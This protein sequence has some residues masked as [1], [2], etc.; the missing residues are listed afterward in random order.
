[1]GGQKREQKKKSHHGC[2]RCKQR[3]CDEKRPDCSNCIKRQEICHYAAS[4]P[5]LWTQP[6]IHV[7]HANRTASASTRGPALHRQPPN[8]MSRPAKGTH[9][10]P[11]LMT[12]IPPSFP[13]IKTSPH[14]HPLLL[15]WT[16]S[17]CHSIARTPIDGRIWQTVIPQQALRC[18]QLFHGLLAVS[19][20]HLAL[21]QSTLAPS[22]DHQKSS[23]ITAAEHH[24]SAAITLLTQAL[25]ISTDTDKTTTF[26]LSCLLVGFAF[27]F[28]LAVTQD[29]RQNALDDLL[30]IF[31][32]IH[33]MM[34]FSTPTIPHLRTS[35]MGDL[36]HL[37]HDDNTNTLKNHLPPNLSPSSRQ[38]ITIILQHLNHSL[39]RSSTSSSREYSSGEH[40][41]YLTTITH[42][43]HLLAEHD[44][45]D[46]T[47]PKDLV[48]A[49]FLWI[50]SLPTGFLDL[51]RHRRPLAL[52]ILAH[53]CVVLHALRHRWWIAGWGR[54]VLQTVCD[55]LKAE[56][57][58][59]EWKVALRWV[60]GEIE[61]E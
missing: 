52:V 51:L 24:Q 28:P 39:T 16:T 17:T 34:A 33:K 7:A 37:D 45:T 35:E 14:H 10:D 57:E 12:T 41:I 59:E 48:S 38:A 8:P 49:S 40:L 21:Q 25:P 15:N 6:S 32:H 13:P 60:W 27:A 31:T 2:L 44:D 54:Q 1:M 5:W 11:L 43:G 56:G 18:P 46:P 61:G 42:L 26:A 20:L 29:H 53:Y 9:Q 55:I 30:N 50:C 23:L 47:T 19:S 3:S 58:E 4:G 22:Q 36:L